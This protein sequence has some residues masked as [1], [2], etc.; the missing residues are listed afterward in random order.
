MR[1]EIIDAIDISTGGGKESVGAVIVFEGG[2]PLKSQYRRYRIRTVAGQDDP[3]MLREVASRRYSR[4]LREGNKIPDLILVDGGKQQLEAVVTA[5]KEAGFGSARVVALAK[6]EEEIYTPERMFPLKLPR[7]SRAL[8]L[9]E[10]ARDEAHRFAISYHRQVR[11]KRLRESVLDKVPGIGIKRKMLLLERFG[12]VAAIRNA[13]IEDIAAVK[14][15]SKK[16]AR[17]IHDCTRP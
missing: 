14:G 4:F 2:R 16:I 11:G 7:D 5:V 3:A 1:P 17:I 12:S 8:R 6:Q 15:I 9:L 10:Y 13:S